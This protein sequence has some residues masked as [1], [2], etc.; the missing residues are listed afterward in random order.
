MEHTNA[1]D[2]VTVTVGTRELDGIVCDASNSAKV[3]VAVIGRDRGPV[4]RTV[5]LS[6]LAERTE[7][8][9]NDV[10]LRLLVRRTP[11]GGRGRGQSGAGSVAD[12]AGHRRASM[13][14]TTGK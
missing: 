2:L 9:P 1:G 8:G 13:H 5:A 4:L 3:V 11:S 12:R 6:D 10:A 7:A 14:R